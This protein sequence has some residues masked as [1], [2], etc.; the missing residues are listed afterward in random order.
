[1]QA[2]NYRPTRVKYVDTQMAPA[3]RRMGSTPAPEHRTGAPDRVG[4]HPGRAPEGHTHPR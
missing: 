3:R 2:T 4:E 1:M